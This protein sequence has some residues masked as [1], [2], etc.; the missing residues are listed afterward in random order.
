MK[1]A[2]ES[3]CFLTF[4]SENRSSIFKTHAAQSFVNAERQ[5]QKFANIYIC[6]YIYSS[7]NIILT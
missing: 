3:S 2:F 1:G 6:M 5:Y 7:L 4:I